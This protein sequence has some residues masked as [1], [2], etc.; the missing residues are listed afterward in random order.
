MT[1]SDP[2]TSPRMSDRRTRSRFHPSDL[3]QNVLLQQRDL[4]VLRDLFL[5][6]FAKG[7]ALY[8]SAYAAQETPGMTNWTKRLPLLWNKRWMSR[9]DPKRSRYLSGAKHFYY[10]LETG[11][12]QEVARLRVP[13]FAL[14]DEQ[15]ALINAAVPPLRAQVSDMLVGQGFS[16][17]QVDATLHNNSELALKFISDQPSDVPHMILGS[18]VLAI[19]W[20]GA[21]QLG[22]TVEHILADG[23]VSLSFE[24]DGKQVPI[25]PDGFFTIGEYAFALEAETGSTAR[26]K[27]IEKIDR[28]LL[29]NR[30][31]GISGVSSMTGARGITS[32]RVLFH[33]QTDAHARMI[34]DVISERLPKKGTG[35]FLITRASDLHLGDEPGGE[36]WTR[37]HFVKDLPVA[38]GTPLYQHLATRITSP[39]F[40]QVTGRSDAAAAITKIPLFAA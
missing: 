22:S 31:K 20:F 38:D 24:D 10:T 3:T 13:Y 33:C 29:L 23:A 34:E 7:Q 26:H 36:K 11:R 19:L 32:F 5:L 25:K 14:T 21:R 2:L 18:T 30:E 1:V 6:R 17:D 15:S 35:L 16:Y 9:F 37:E 4:A 27:I 8:L 40:S 28:Y 39:I 12:A